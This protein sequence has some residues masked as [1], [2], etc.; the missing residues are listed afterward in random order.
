MLGPEPQLKVLGKLPSHKRKGIAV[1]RVFLAD[2]I[3]GLT[4]GR[5]DFIRYMLQQQS[6]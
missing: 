5:K 6:E 2:Y 4:K 1:F 3:V